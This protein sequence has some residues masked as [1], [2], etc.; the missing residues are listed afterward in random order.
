MYVCDL[1]SGRHMYMYVCANSMALSVVVF[2]FFFSVAA[3][4]EAFLQFS[5]IHSFISPQYLEIVTNVMKVIFFFKK[6]N[7]S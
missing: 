7:V 3:K 1:Q 2:F 5:F 4:K 6:K